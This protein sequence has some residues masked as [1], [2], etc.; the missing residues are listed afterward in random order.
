MLDAA[1]W[2]AIGTFAVALGT[3][4]LAVVTVR[5]GAADRRPDDEKRA[6][7]RERDDR[8]R[9][10]ARGQAERREN[11]ERI[12]REDYEAR[13]VLVTVEAKERRSTVLG[14]GRGAR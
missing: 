3:F 10:E 13:Q 1:G 6:A 7:D 8:L 5:T 2:T 9:E 11:A 4:V 14:N 12:A